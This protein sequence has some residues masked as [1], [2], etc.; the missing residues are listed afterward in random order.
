MIIPANI[1][2]VAICEGTNVLAAAGAAKSETFTAIRLKAQSSGRVE[3]VVAERRV[4]MRKTPRDSEMTNSAASTFIDAASQN[5]SGWIISVVIN[6][7]N[8][9][10]ILLAK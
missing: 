5:N 1:K 9:G 8:R 4:M 3:M 6:P 2:A 10:S 7:A